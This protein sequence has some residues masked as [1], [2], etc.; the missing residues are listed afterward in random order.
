MI[1][2]A[3]EQISYGLK[4][5]AFLQID[6]DRGVRKIPSLTDLSR[7]LFARHYSV[8]DCSMLSI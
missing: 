7:Y 6:I 1:K 2:E 4:S 3:V 5:S 8:N